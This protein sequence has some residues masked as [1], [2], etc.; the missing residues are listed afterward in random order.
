MA[1]ALSLLFTLNADGQPAVEEFKRVRTAFAAELE[2]LKK[3]SA[4]AVKTSVEGPGQGSRPNEGAAQ[5][6]ISTSKTIVDSQRE[7]NRQI[8]AMWADREKGQAASL[9][10]QSVLW[11]KHEAEK[12]ATTRQ[13]EKQSEAVVAASQAAKDK[14]AKQ[15]ADNF[16]R[17]QKQISADVARANAQNAANEIRAALNA[18]KGTA[19]ISGV[20]SKGIRD[21]ADNVNVFVGQRI[22]LFGGAFLR[23]TD[24]LRNF[25]VLTGNVEAS[26][27]RL[28]KAI[29]TL[30]VGSG[31][32][33]DEIKKFLSGF[34]DLGT[35][36]EKDAAAIEFFGAATAQKLLPA[37]GTAEAEMAG[38]TAATAEAGS[39]LG[40][41]IAATGPVGFAIAAVAFQVATLVV[42]IKLLSEVGIDVTKRFFDLAKS[43]AGFRGEMV[44]LSQQLGLSTETL[45]AFEIFAKTTGGNIGSIT[46]ALGI[47]QRKLEEGRDPATKAGQTFSEL[48]VDIRD[49]ETALRQTLTA[50]AAMPEGF[51][52]TAT[53]LELFGRGGKSILAILKEMHGDLDGAI[54]RFRKMGLIISK[55]DAEAADKF[56]DQLLILELK[57]RALL[58][59]DVIPA[60]TDAVEDFSKFI[61]ENREE[62]RLLNDILGTL[63]GAV[64]TLFKVVLNEFRLFQ[65]ALEFHI[66]LWHKLADAIKAVADIPPV[67]PAPDTPATFPTPTSLPSP[68]SDLTKA[69]EQ[70]RLVRAEIDEAVRFANDQVSAI[71]R[72]LRAREISQATALETIIATEKEKTRLVVEGL[73]RQQEARAKEVAVDEAAKQKQFEDVQEFNT[74]IRAAED[75]FRKLEADKRTEFRAQELERE[76]AHRR[77][78]LETFNKALT[79]QIASL[80]R[81]AEL[82]R[83]PKLTA[84]DATIGIIEQQFKARKELLE[85]EQR[86]AGADVG[87]RQRIADQLKDLEQQKTIVLREQSNRRED[88]VRE[89]AKNSINIQLAA[90]ERILRIGQI[91]DASRITSLRFLAD[92][93]VKS[94]E[95]VA[96]AILKIQLDALQREDDAIRARLTAAKSIS[97]P[98]ERLKAETDLNNQLKINQA[99]REAI[100]NEGNRDIDEARKRDL[101][102]LRRYASEIERI[103]ERIADIEIDTAREVI[104]L[105]KL[106]FA[107]GKDIIRAQRDLELREEDN[108]H[109][110]ITNSIKAQQSEVGE[111]IR[112][113][114]SHLKSLKIG[115]DEEIAE[116]ERLIAELEKLRLKRAQLTA[117]QEAE[118]TRS[119]TR[120]RRVSDEADKDLKQATP[121]GALGIDVGGLKELGRAILEA[122]SA[123]L[124]TLKRL[125]GELQDAA[126]QFVAE[127]ERSITPLGEIL[128]GTFNQV[129][130]AI[131]QTVE[132]WVLL[133]TTGPAVMRKILAQA[134]ASLAREATFNAIKE[135]ALGFATLFFNPAESAA[136]FTAAAL[137]GSIAGA[138]A[139]LGRRT[140]GDLFKQKGTA[141]RAASGGAEPSARNASFNLG[142]QGPVETSLR[143]AQEGSGGGIFGRLVAR[144]ETLQQQ[145]MEMQRQQM[146][147]QGQTAQ[148]LARIQSMRH[149][150]ALAI[151]AEENPAAVGRAVIN[152]SNSDGEFNEGLQRNLGFAR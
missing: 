83:T 133:G 5:A 122:L 146:L 128:T 40:A 119:K 4:S 6:A 142:G 93:R 30:A 150:D 56:N 81:S 78:R 103:L 117:E 129:A 108:R 123:P 68:T 113:L 96:R 94:E 104:E 15:S 18:A 85:R 66:E 90:A 55:E 44:D 136:H 84:V 102:N 32:S 53:A 24:N 58:G 1:D 79:D 25:N 92:A 14:A 74:K 22:P 3:L 141:G 114:E 77:A 111:Q 61:D 124:E 64:S 62:I 67:L 37:L 31:K 16:L 115:T 60:A 27:L 134:L 121:L 110:R 95:A 127:I 26:T 52:Q 12:L 120:K 97:D 48:S 23:I 76:Q 80:N 89:E 17:I 2:G 82:G 109:Q 29:N 11:T 28:G 125:F 71:D 36:T 91:V 73:Q 59:R 57:F 70:A 112:I 69:K 87:L 20:A 116:H 63:A 137:W 9:K 144:I 152:H 151:G 39:G 100:Q 147:V 149:G 140:A 42:A 88:I 99:E 21:L 130:D 41:L 49:T 107:R 145:T 72:Q 8:E 138:S 10:R 19:D 105:M 118:D 34:K 33:A 75:A 131:G 54:E 38:L 51:H 148:A 139:L 43:A 35:Q 7:V 126:R 143:A 65:P 106:H 135:L 98:Q 86:E 45:S 132:N 50:L 46:A 101:Q 13:A 47:F